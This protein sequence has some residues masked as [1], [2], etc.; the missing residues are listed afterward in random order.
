MKIVII[1]NFIHHRNDR[2]NNLKKERQN[3]QEQA[4][5]STQQ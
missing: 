4:Q 2:E 1:F 5:A 3:K